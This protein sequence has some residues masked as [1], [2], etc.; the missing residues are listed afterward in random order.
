MHGLSGDRDLEVLF[1]ENNQAERS[2]CY[3]RS[4]L[5]GLKERV[6]V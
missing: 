5:T 6:S 4:T 2:H 1:I 3:N